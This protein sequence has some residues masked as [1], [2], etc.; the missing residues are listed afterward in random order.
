M[1]L[2]WE[3]KLKRL[4]HWDRVLGPTFMMMQKLQKSVQEWLKCNSLPITLQS[5]LW[6][7]KLG[8]AWIWKFRLNLPQ[9]R[10]V[11]K[12]NTLNTTRSD[13]GRLQYG[14]KVAVVGLKK[15]TQLYLAACLTL[16]MHNTVPTPTTSRPLHPQYGRHSDWIIVNWRGGELKIFSYTFIQ[17]SWKTKK[18]VVWIDL[19]FL[20]KNLPFRLL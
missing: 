20:S 14:I 3:N 7:S 16:D 15:D 13:A 18:K 6:A 10:W 12:R 17:C 8:W 11:T 1:V 9:I 2:M 19:S 4:N 5:R